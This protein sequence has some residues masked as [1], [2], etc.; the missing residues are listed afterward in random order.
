MEAAQNVPDVN[1]RCQS[2]SEPWH[3]TLMGLPSE[4]TCLMDFGG[5]L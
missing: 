2:H 4:P 5:V 3:L 1:R